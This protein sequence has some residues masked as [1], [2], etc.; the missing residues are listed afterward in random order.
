MFLGS[1]AVA[2]VTNWTKERKISWVTTN[3]KVLRLQFT[4]NHRNVL[5]HVS[6]EYLLVQ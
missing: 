5:L 1:T 4:S 3:P 2:A 6:H